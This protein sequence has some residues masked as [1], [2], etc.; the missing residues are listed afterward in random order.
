MARKILKYFTP[1][2]WA[3][4][5]GGMAAIAAGFFIGEDKNLLSLF[6]S[7]F[8]VTLII[9]NAKGNVWGQVF[10]IC[11]SVLYGILSYTKA[12]YGEMIIYF[13]LMTPIHIASIVIWL[14]N[15]NKDAKRLEV[16]INSLSALEYGIAAVFT[17][18]ATVAFYF[19]LQA[20]NTDN[21]I[22]ST[23]SLVTSLAA[24]YLMLRRCEY[25]SICFVLNDIILI[26]MWSLKLST[27]GISVLPSVLCFSIFLINDAYCY[28]SWRKIKYRQR[29]QLDAERTE[30]TE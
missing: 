16:K 29:E 18:A 22:I 8:G 5:L 12:Y 30:K 6:S 13:A 28:L 27:D 24:A 25:F 9:F 11:F 10:A 3:L 23:I 20:L 17:A 19:I 7:L 4:W 26:I 14:K 21:L 1:F 15:L 2:E